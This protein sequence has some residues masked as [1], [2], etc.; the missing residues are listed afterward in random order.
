M[1]LNF[2]T[3]A[4]EPNMRYPELI[5]TD[6]ASIYR[7]PLHSFW[8]EDGR[9]IISHYKPAEAILEIKLA[10]DSDTDLYKAGTYFSERVGRKNVLEIYV[11]AAEFQSLCSLVLGD[12]ANLAD[13]QITLPDDKSNPSIVVLPVY[14]EIN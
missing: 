5:Y 4:S 8:I 1:T 6:D 11:S 2:K 3:P 13:L 7:A 14:V 12:K 10:S 9:R